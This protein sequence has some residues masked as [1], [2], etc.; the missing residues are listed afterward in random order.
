VQA[1]SVATTLQNMAEFYDLNNSVNINVG[2]FIWVG[3]EKDFS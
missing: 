3:N 1:F 2:M